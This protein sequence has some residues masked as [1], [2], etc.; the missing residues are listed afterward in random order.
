MK[1]SFVVKTEWAEQINLLS[2]E[3]AGQLLKAWLKYHLDEPSVITDPVVEMAFSFNKSYFDDNAIRYAA[4]V[5]AN[6]DNG[7]KGGR[8]KK[9]NGFSENPE[10]PM[11]FSD[12]PTKAKKPVSE[13]E[14]ES[15]SESDSVSPEGD[16]SAHAHRE[17]GK[18]PKNPKKPKVQWAENVV[19][20]N[21]EHDKLLAA[22]GPVDTARL[23]E[24]LDNY[25]GSVGK[26]Y[27]SDYRAILSWCVDKLKEEKRKEGKNQSQKEPPGAIHQHDP[28]QVSASMEQMRR[29]LG[30]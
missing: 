17:R 3:Q 14:S 27:D 19:M 25:K 6:R 22:H 9:P 24:I 8:P 2:D 30:K 11:G 12:N 10:N 29:V 16:K 1:D 4:K 21:D 28:S 20:T 13:S 18:K 7:K 15:E 23:I 26:K 5:S